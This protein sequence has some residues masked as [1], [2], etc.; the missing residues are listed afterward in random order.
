MFYDRRACRRIP[1]EGWRRR[2]Q[3]PSNP[4]PIITRRRDGLQHTHPFYKS[5]TAAIEPV[6]GNLIAEE[7][8]RARKQANSETARM[9]RTLDALGRDL[10]RL[11]DED[12]REIDEEGLLGSGESLPPIKLVPEQSVLYLGEEKTIT[13]VV[14]ADL[15]VHE[16][17]CAVEPGGVVE[18]MDG[19]TA[20]L[21]PHKRRTDVLTGQIRLKPLLEDETLLTVTAGSDAAVGLIEVRSEREIVEVEMPQPD[22]LQFERS[23]Y[24]IS[25]TRKKRLRLM[26]P[27]E[28]VDAEGKRVRVASTD[29]GVVVRGGETVLKLDE[30]G[31]FYIGEVLIE[32]R[33]LGAQSTLSARLGSVIA[34]CKVLVTREEDGPNVRI[35]IEAEEAGARRAIVEQ[36]E[37]ITLIKIMGFHPA[38]RRYLGPPPEFP[39][40]DLSISRAILAEI[41]ADQAARLVMERKFPTAS[42]HEQLDAARFYFEHYKYAAKYLA[43]AQD[44][45]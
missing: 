19:A 38:I 16:I 27:V 44:P 17:G 33:T 34:T 31:E 45:D 18:L 1:T 10:S 21:T 13:A 8:K 32:A 36:K 26:A 28:L 37:G 5:L 23:N 20:K 2:P 9:R 41:I 12:L 7:E 6:L 35:V 39:L 14:R 22:H 24:R 42:G 40:Q 3:D 25:W 43:S 30:D 11:I 4:V 15:G 29:P